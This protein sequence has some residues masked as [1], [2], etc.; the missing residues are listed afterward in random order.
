MRAEKKY[1]L[2]KK[3]KEL[4]DSM[5]IFE[6]EQADY[7]NGVTFLVKGWDLINM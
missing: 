4:K 7:K 5:K 3:L 2:A 6:L 1:S